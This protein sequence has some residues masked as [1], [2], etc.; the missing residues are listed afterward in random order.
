MCPLL[1]RRRAGDEV[2]LRKL[3]RNF[4]YK[5]FT[6]IPVN[7]CPLLFPNS[8]YFGKENGRGCGKQGDATLKKN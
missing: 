6:S 1:G 3:K 2:K 5:R 7:F 8:G 4:N